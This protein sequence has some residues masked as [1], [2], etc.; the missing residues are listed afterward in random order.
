MLPRSAPLALLALLAA[1]AR[2]ADPPSGRW[3]WGDLHAHSGWSYDGCEDAEAGCA[4]RG[5]LPGE[6]FFENAAAAGLDFAALT[7]HAEAD[8][9]GPEGEEGALWDIWEEQAAVVQRARGGPV[10]PILGYEW[11]AFR[12]DQLDGHRRGSHRTVLLGSDDACVPRRISG[13]FL[14]ADP[15]LGPDGLTVFLQED[16]EVMDEA[17]ELWEALDEAEEACGPTR[18][19]S[20]AHHPA[21]ELPQ[22]T[23]WALDENRPDRETLVEIASEHGSS[24]CAD[25]D[26][27]G[28]AWRINEVQGYFPEGSVQAALARGF[29][30][31]FTGGTDGHDA[32]PGSLED[33][34]GRVG[35]LDGDG[36]PRLQFMDGAL[37]G[38]FLE[39]GQE[40]GIEALFDALEAR[41]TLATT[42]PR[43]ALSA[44]AESEDGRV[45]LPGA[46][47]PRDAGPLTLVL[48]AGDAGEGYRLDRVERVGVDGLVEDASEEAE[49]RFT[50]D[51]GPGDWTYLRLRYASEAAADGEERVW[52]SPWFVERRCECASGASPAGALP[53]LLA[54]ILGLRRRQSSVPASRRRTLST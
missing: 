52:V 28:C 26:A 36:L 40:L 49:A 1:P 44:W 39:E 13:F 54:L 34:P 16:E 15:Y 6:D 43:P 12:E 20:F 25:P 45:W 10:L 41:R 4:P 50:W 47:L 33:G 9:W 22:S 51:P 18:W 2:A 42:G 27:E 30:L 35:Q 46:L 48:E 17:P 3:V 7:D 32:R 14:R 24:E 29:R 8:R 38:V 21:Y 31:G 5:A 37:T 19:I 23:D 53:A 11:T